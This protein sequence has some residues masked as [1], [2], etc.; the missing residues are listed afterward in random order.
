MNSIRNIPIDKSRMSS[1]EKKKRNLV[2]ANLLSSSAKIDGVSYCQ[3]ELRAWI[4]R[5]RGAEIEVLLQYSV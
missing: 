1:K 5:S 3:T 4:E 2:S